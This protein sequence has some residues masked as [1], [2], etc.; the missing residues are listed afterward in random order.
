[1]TPNFALIAALLVAGS[2]TTLV[3][4]QEAPRPQPVDV[5]P[6]TSVAQP[7]LAAP[8]WMTKPVARQWNVDRIKQAQTGLQNAKLYGGR[9]SGVYD[10]ETRH[11]VREYQRLHNLAVT[12][13]LSDSL[14]VMLLAEQP[15]RPC[16]SMP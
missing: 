4:R 6:D 15:S 13:T 5:R 1:M 16:P 3:A 7:Q 11:A 14:M 10:G 2:S 12:G 8:P 9:V